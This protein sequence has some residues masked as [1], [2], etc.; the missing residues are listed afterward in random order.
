MKVLEIDLYKEFNLTR[1]EGSQGYLTAYLPENY[2]EVN[3]NR[4][5]PAMIVVGGGGYAMV[6]GREKECVVFK[7]LEKG[8]ACFLLEYSVAPIRYPYAQLEGSMAIAYLRKNAKELSVREDNIACVGFSAGGH[9]VGCLSN[10]F[11]SEV[12]NVLGED[13]ALVRPDASLMIYP[14]VTSGEKSHPGS[15]KN[16]VAKMKS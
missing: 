9:L 2:P 3:V 4:R 6:S 12:L 14:V 11:E 15:F 1:P 16:L 8:Y 13:K 7:F 5:R 10:L